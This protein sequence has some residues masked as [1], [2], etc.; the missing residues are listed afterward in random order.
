MR[1]RI[2][3]GSRSCLEKMYFKTV[4]DTVQKDLKTAQIGGMPTKTS[5]VRGYVRVLDSRKELGD[6]SSLA[7]IEAADGSKDYCWVILYIFLRCGLIQEA[8][9]YVQQ[10]IISMRSVDRKFP[11]YILEYSQNPGRLLSRENRSTIN[12][13]Y[14][15]STKMVADGTVDPYRAACYKIVGRCELSRRVLDNINTDEEDWVWLQFTL[16]REVLRSE[17]QAGEVFGLDQIRETVTDI[18][19]RHFS[20]ASDNPG[21]F[22][23]FFFMQILASMF[24]KAVAWLYPQNHISAVHFAIALDYYGLLRA[25]DL[26]ATE[27][28]KSNSPK[29]YS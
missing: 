24:K 22:G 4:K 19:K 2:L 14:N 26:G 8:A 11:P 18:G 15:Q 6:T 20:Q 12:T 28:C 27:L 9:E 16:A 21:G 17:E 7:N 25:G 23:L 5:T 29:T 3:Q 13:K 1:K 10:N